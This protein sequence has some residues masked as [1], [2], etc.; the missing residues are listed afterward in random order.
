MRMFWL[1]DCQANRQPLKFLRYHTRTASGVADWI[2]TRLGYAVSESEML[3]LF[4]VSVSMLEFM[5]LEILAVLYGIDQ[6]VLRYLTRTAGQRTERIPG[7]PHQPYDQQHS[8]QKHRK[9]I[10]QRENQL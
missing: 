5:M 2:T 1:G 4:R 8:S 9:Q 6:A 10:C 7:K 3:R